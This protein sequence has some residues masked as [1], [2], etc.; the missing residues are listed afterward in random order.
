M[1]SI[2]DAL[3]RAD[4][5]RRRENSDLT[6]EVSRHTRRSWSLRGFLILAGVLLLG[7]FLV[8]LFLWRTD[9]PADTVSVQ[10]AER[11]AVEP[12]RRVT[13]APP[14]ASTGQAE[15]RGGVVRPQSASIEEELKHRAR[16]G[17]RPLLDE[18]MLDPLTINPQPFHSPAMAKSASASDIRASRTPDTETSV[19]STAEWKQLVASLA[20]ATKQPDAGVALDEPEIPGSTPASSPAATQEPALSEWERVPTI[21]EAPS[22]V[23]ARLE[24]L[25]ISVHLYHSEPSK[26]FVIINK[27]RYGEEDSLEYAGLR[28]KRIT[29][30]GIIIDYGDGEVRM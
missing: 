30:E 7:N 27:H 20:P 26:R 22:S 1:S 24:G 12:P 5:E 11:E 9:V 25:K 15:N 17:A 14:P 29:R 6:G 8:W 21:W 18:A 19:P 28:L 4:Q 10:E 23:R 16:P 2:L 13:A 3:D